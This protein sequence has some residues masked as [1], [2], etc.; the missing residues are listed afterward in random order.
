MFPYICVFSGSSCLHFKQSL[1]IIGGICLFRAESGSTQFFQFD[2]QG[3]MYIFAPG[4]GCTGPT[5]LVR[6]GDEMI[7]NSSYNAAERCTD[8]ESHED[9]ELAFTCPSTSTHCTFKKPLFKSDMMALSHKNFSEE[10]M[11]QIRWV[12]KMYHEWHSHRQALGLQDIVCDLEDNA[13]ITAVSLKFALCRFITEVKKVDVSDFPGKTLYHIIICIQFHLETQGFAFKLVNDP[14]FKDLKFTL[15]NTMKA[16]TLQG[17]GT[18]MKQ[19]EILSAMDEDLLWSLGLLSMSMPHQF[20]HTMIFSIG[21]GFALRAGKE[22]RA[23]CDLAFDSQFT[24]MR[25]PDGEVFLRYAEDIGLKTNKGGI[26]HCKI[27]VKTMD[28]YATGHEERC[29]LRTIINY[30]SLMPQ[31]RTCRAFYL[32][33]QKK[34]F[35]KLWYVNRPAVVNTLHNAMRDLCRQA[36]LPR[37]YTNHSL[38]STAA[39][40]LYHHSVDEQVIMEITGHR[41]L[42]VHGYKRTLDRQRKLASNCLFSDQWSWHLPTDMTI[43]HWVPPFYCYPSAL[44]VT[45]Q[46]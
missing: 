8:Q 27:D 43:E 21:K 45:S 23:L 10:T 46:S 3:N 37:Y 19:A 2:S 44:C 13:M 22:H 1:V 38:Q 39:T 35:A 6:P 11:K 18:S 4:A 29:P 26:K 24:F 16:R 42:V 14:A 25:D 5:K 31:N 9:K 28:L 32:Q 34:W 15:D 17:I 40:K 33:P 7:F 36:G 41:S 30:L 12:R 20:L